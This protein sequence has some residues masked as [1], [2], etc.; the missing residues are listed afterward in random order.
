MGDG[1]HLMGH[2]RAQDR[3]VSWALCPPGGS[4]VNFPATWAFPGLPSRKSESGS[5]DFRGPDTGQFS[6]VSLESG[7]GHLGLAVGTDDPQLQWWTLLLGGHPQRAM[8]VVY[9]GDS[10]G[11]QSQF[12]QKPLGSAPGRSGRRTV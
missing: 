8:G 6:D 5:W 7:M 1:G 4:A 11:R 9:G 2:C 12:N 3:F 10:Q